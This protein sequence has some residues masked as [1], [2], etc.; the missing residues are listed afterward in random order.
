MTT[1]DTSAL[2]AKRAD[3]CLIVCDYGFLS[4]LD[5]ASSWDDK[6]K[7]QQYDAVKGKSEP[8]RASVRA[9]T[10]VLS[11][12]RHSDVPWPIHIFLFLGSRAVALSALVLR[13]P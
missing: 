3:G 8:Q 10:R 2:Q 13:I 9:R 6:C 7:V 11:P 1:S 12:F 4:Y 5:E